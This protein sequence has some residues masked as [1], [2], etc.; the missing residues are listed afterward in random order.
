VRN[1][2][3]CIILVAFISLPILSSE[4]HDLVK[5]SDLEGVRKI[6]KA[7]RTLVNAK[8]NN[9][10]TPLMW[11]CNIGDVVIARY[12]LENKADPDIKDE[13]DST[14]LHISANSGNLELVKLLLQ[15]ETSSINAGAEWDNT[16]L[17]LAC[18]RRH[19]EVVRVLVENGA[20]I[21]ARNA[22]KRT[23]IIAAGR[24][25]G[26]LEII[27][28]L[29][30][31]GADIHAMDVWNDTALALAAWR[32]FEE[33]VNFLIERK[34]IIPE[35][36]KEATLRYAAERGLPRL[37]QYMLENGLNLNEIKEHIKNLHHAA[38]GGGS[39]EIVKSLIQHGFDINQKDKDGWTPLHYA[40][41][42]GKNEM[43]KYLIASG[44]DKN[45]RNI[46]GETAYHI[47]IF[48]DNPESAELLKK[49]GVD[50]S[51]PKFPVLK[52]KY[53]GQKP[54]GDEPELFMP[55]IVS[56]HYTSHCSLI[57]SPDGKEAYWTEQ[58]PS[59]EKDYGT[60]GVMHMKMVG[61]KWTYPK[62][63]EVMQGEPAFS[64][65]GKRLYFISQKPL[66]PND[67]GGKENIWYMVK[68]D[69]GWSEPKPVDNTVNSKRLHWQISV[70]KNYNLYFADWNS[71]YYSEYKNGKYQK[72]VN[73]AELYNNETLKGCCPFISPDSDYLLFTA[74]KDKDN[75][76]NHDIHISFKKKDG[77]WTNAI[78][79]GD[80]INATL[81]DQCPTV[82]PDGK[83]LFFLSVGKDRPWGI[84]WVGAGIIEELRKKTS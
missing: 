38:A 69:S 20:D 7:D 82:T 1:F 4:I 63:S 84:Y 75:R 34:S 48:R 22:L 36:G 15:N 50:Y 31:K 39:I 17:H 58:Y 79:L 12:L 51:T 19:P 35:S 56:G 42:Q 24:E 3:S 45:A 25:S 13:N 27:R 26:C 80:K 44:I 54:P 65:D 81:H 43:I 29:V 52:G 78:N 14:A 70:D 49:S 6:L 41:G 76:R 10:K 61:D 46:K 5:E 53:M 62:R 16:P 74:P 30:E 18:E 71:I 21:E 47:A 68:I 83:Y 33:V 28:F 2:M 55:G 9:G 77:T 73:I 72:P 40:A 32:G 57:F 11:A 23:P 67:K 37:Y 66:N 60:G 64:P 8:D 59:K